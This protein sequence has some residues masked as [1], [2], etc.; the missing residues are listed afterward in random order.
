MCICKTSGCGAGSCWFQ[1]LLLNCWFCRVPW[2]APSSYLKP[3]LTHSGP[4]LTTTLPGCC[5]PLA[6]CLT[7]PQ[8]Y[9]VS[10]LCIYTHMSICTC[11]YCIC[12]HTQ[13]T[14]KIVKNFPSSSQSCLTYC[15]AALVS[16]IWHVYAASRVFTPSTPHLEEAV[17]SLNACAYVGMCKGG[18]ES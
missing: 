14:R 9:E 2:L 18:F 8:A 13:R 3:I 17:V 11:T 6:R 1:A 12:I 5:G 16:Y 10:D 4:P 7:S 15:K